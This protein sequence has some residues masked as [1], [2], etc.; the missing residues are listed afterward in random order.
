MSI[1]PA[2]KTDYVGLATTGLEL[3]SNSLGKSGT[4][5]K[6]NK[7]DGSIGASLLFGEIAAPSCDYV[8]TGTVTPTGW[9]LGKVHGSGSVPYA[10]QSVTISTSAGGEP[11]VSANAVQIEA[12]ATATACTYP[13]P[14]ITLSPEF[15]AQNFGAFSFTASETLDLQDN[16]LTI[17]AD[18]AP[19]TING[20][21][22]ASDAV[23][24]EA[25]ASCTFWSAS[26]TTAPAVTPGEGWELSAPW[27]CT[28]NDGDL[29]T[30]T[31]S[32]S[33]KLSTAA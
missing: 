2:E 30:W 19:V 7:A 29:F 12:G 1:S 17:S 14:S 16:S 26:E 25:V 31:A 6:K 3:R 5:L 10:L 32:F 28:G 27:T 9:A 13:I 21:P 23:G 11:T 18:I 20:E 15:H 22:K 33:K 24:G 4:Y 8:I